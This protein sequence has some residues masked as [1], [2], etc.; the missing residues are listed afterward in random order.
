M[1]DP[2]VGSE[3]GLRSI[4]KATCAAGKTKIGSGQEVH[5]EGM[6]VVIMAGSS[7]KEDSPPN[8]DEE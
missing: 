8:E 1:K 5:H 7:T 3:E 2:K 6:G 4:T